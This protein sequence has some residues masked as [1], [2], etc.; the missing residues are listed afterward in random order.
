LK[1]LVVK[2]SSMGDVVHAMPAVTD[3]ARALP[4]ITIDWLVEAPFAALPALH[5]DVRTV[6]SMS[7][8]KW[9]KKLWRS[10]TW[11][12]MSTCRDQLRAER[13]DVV[14]DLQGLLKSVL[15]AGQARGTLVGYDRHSAR[16]AAASWFYRR[17]APV[18][19]NMHAVERCRRAASFH[20][21]YS[22]PSNAPEFG[23]AVPPPG[24]LPSQPDYL[25]LIPCAS[26][27]EKHWPLA[28]WRALVTRCE[29]RGVI[30]VILWGS[31]AELSLARQIAQATSAVIPPFLK[32]ADM[33]GLLAGARVVV[34]LDTG[35]THLAA[36][37]ARPTVGI[38]CDH[39]PG[40]AGVTGPSF[41]CSLGGR[42]QV[43]SFDE[44]VQAFDAAWTAAQ[45]TG[46]R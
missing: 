7:W 39:E 45:V 14:L 35:F 10:D 6:I 32:V 41:V 15:W 38:Y 33:A 23:L 27:V 11:A 42:G 44:V 16:E 30:P 40:L 25:V 5:P 2:T 24:W 3:M 18:P 22:M 28:H 19:R 46:F 21:G 12:A 13:Y 34:G 36:A 26:R 20:L 43:P 17:G 37:L 1:V 31:A 29:A 4:G 8:R 9:R